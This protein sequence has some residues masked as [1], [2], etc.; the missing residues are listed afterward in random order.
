[1]MRT[2]D[3]NLALGS[4]VSV[5]REVRSA[6]EDLVSRL[7][8]DSGAVGDECLEALEAAE[9]RTRKLVELLESRSKAL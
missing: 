9:A 5:V 8:L 7:R 1:M 6:F 3:A 2:A 4:A